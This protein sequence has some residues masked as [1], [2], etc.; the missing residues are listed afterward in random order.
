MEC[1][2]FNPVLS[3]HAM[4]SSISQERRE[5]Y[6]SFSINKSNTK[7]NDNKVLPDA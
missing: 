7:L 5:I 3:K 1:L 4:E 6:L 2:T